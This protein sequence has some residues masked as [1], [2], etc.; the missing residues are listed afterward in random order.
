MAPT[1]GPPTPLV[2]PGLATM[3]LSAAA[4]PAKQPLSL[5]ATEPSF[6]IFG[7]GPATGDHR[8]RADDGSGYGASSSRPLCSVGVPPS[9]PSVNGPWKGTAD[10][11]SPLY[12]PGDSASVAAALEVRERKKPRRGGDDGGGGTSAPPPATT[13]LYCLGTAAAQAVDG[14]EESLLFEGQSPPVLDASVWQ[15]LAEGWESE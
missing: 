13:A 4:K 2:L 15:V 10:S 1:M 6:A 8:E 11:L 3:P 12:V 7:R 9:P 14:A 5:A